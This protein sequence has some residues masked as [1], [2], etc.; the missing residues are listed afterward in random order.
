MNPGLRTRSISVD[1][2]HHGAD[3]AVVIEAHRLQA[4]P[5]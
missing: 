5:E 2:H 3:T 1:A 4:G